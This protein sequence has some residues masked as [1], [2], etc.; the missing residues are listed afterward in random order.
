VGVVHIGDTI[1]HVGNDAHIHVAYV[2]ISEAG[3]AE[4]V[5]PPADKQVFVTC[6]S[7]IC[8]GPQIVSF[9]SGQK[10]L[11]GGYDLTTAG[12]LEVSRA[13]PNYF[14]ETETG[15]KLRIKTE[16]ATPVAGSINYV[17]LRE[18]EDME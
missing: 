5:D 3:F 9:Y 12:C 10:Q 1:H 4:I 13:Q 11:G 18:H 6:V 14:A 15:K 16:T 8:H 17:L 7:L 2:D